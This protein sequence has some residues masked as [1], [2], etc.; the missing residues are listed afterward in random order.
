MVDDREFNE[1]VNA[2]LPINL[3][4]KINKWLSEESKETIKQ[5]L[6]SIYGINT[7]RI[8][9]ILR[10]KEWVEFTENGKNPS[11]TVQDDG[12]FYLMGKAPDGDKPRVN[13]RKGVILSD[14]EIYNNDIH[15]NYS[16]KVVI[17]KEN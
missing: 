2:N 17:L 8:R 7:F 14:R 12:S 15:H 11:L 3:I 6:K 10:G 16:M 4:N 9:P 5:K 13:A 1:L